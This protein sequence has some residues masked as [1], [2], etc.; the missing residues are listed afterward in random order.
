[1]RE[2]KGQYRK[3][4]VKVQMRTP[5]VVQRPVGRQEWWLDEPAEARDQFLKAFYHPKAAGFGWRSTGL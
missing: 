3:R 1:M 4:R 5:R 2:R